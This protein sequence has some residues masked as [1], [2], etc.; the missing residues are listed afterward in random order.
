MSNYYETS[1]FSPEVANMMVSCML[2][3]TTDS[4]LSEQGFGVLVTSQNADALVQTLYR[5]A[6]ARNIAV[7]TYP[8]N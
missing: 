4:H 1:H 6:D 3:G 2:E 5:Q 7:N 8:D